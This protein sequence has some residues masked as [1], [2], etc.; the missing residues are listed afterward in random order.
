[1]PAAPGFIPTAPQSSVHLLFD[2]PRGGPGEVGIRVLSL[3]REQL[4]TLVE[5]QTATR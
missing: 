3:L 2:E 5:Q 1:M 4:Y